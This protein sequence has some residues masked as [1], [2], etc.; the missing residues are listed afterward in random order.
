LLEVPVPIDSKILEK[1]LLLP[2]EKQQEV[3]DFVEFLSSQSSK[4][5]R[6]SR[7]K[8]ICSDLGVQITAD[9]I[10]D[11]RR[12]AWANFPREDT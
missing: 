6:K 8:G 11:V 5:V 3:A 12:E 7:L 1:V 2:P 9:D 10:D 4:T